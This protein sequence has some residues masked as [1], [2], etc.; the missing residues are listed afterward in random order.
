MASK[1]L[2]STTGRGVQGTPGSSSPYSR[3]SHGSRGHIWSIACAVAVGMLIALSWASVAQEEDPYPRCITGCTA[4]DVT[5]ES[6]RL[7][8]P[9]TC[10]PGSSLAAQIL[11]TVNFNRVNSYCVRFVADVYINNV[12]VVKDIVSQP[13]V[14]QDKGIY[15][16]LVGTVNWTCGSVL[17]LRN[18]QIFWSVD[19]SLYDPAFCVGCVDYGPG[20]KCVGYASVSA[21]TP[22]VANFV[23]SPLSG[24]VPLTV[25]FTDLTTGGWSTSPYTYDWDFGDGSAHSSARDP[26]HTYVDPGT[27]TVSLTVTDAGAATDSETKTSYVVVVDCGADLRVTKTA[28]PAAVFAGET[29][30]YTVVV[31]ND[32]PNT[33]TGVV[34][35]DQ[36]PIGV[37]LLSYGITQGTFSAGTWNVGALAPAGS[38]VLTLTVQVD[39]STH[40]TLTNTACATGNETDPN[41]ANNCGTTTTTV[42]PR[43]DLRVTKTDSPD[44]VIAGQALTYTVVV[45]ND[46]PSDA[47][48]VAVAETLPAGVT[49]TSAT[50]S[51]GTY[52]SST[53]VWTVG[54]LA[55][56]ASA[57]L[58]LVVNV[59]PGTTGTLTN[60]ACATGNE[61]DPN[62]ANNCGTTTTTVTP[63]TDL[64]VT[65]TDSP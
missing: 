62:A 63:R 27:Y 48:G 13:Y 8:Y 49:F 26:L 1:R 42:T 35:T 33:A 12:L 56:G 60:T 7:A 22:L 18:I 3:R 28:T 32:G 9:G 41:A 61:T 36:L 44:P 25:Q 38:A 10:T 23:G 57:T 17:E 43:T 51:V 31:W 5:L 14:F 24:C 52:S 64:R 6:V 47:T 40:G 46:G 50:A 37:S 59:N 11:A 53:N 20:S 45:W 21:T 4:K 30:T 34:V 54:N 16:L 29:L 58:T 39:P 15:E 55:A 19:N 65:K 2:G